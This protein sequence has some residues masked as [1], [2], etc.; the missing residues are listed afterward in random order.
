VAGRSLTARFVT[1]RATR[2]TGEQRELVLFA[3]PAQLDVSALKARLAE[4]LPVASLAV[5]VQSAP[6]PAK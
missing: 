2:G 3:R 4:R 5:R 6:E 1:K